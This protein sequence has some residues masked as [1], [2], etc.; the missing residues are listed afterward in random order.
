MKAP[1]PTPFGRRLREF[2]TRNNMDIARLSVL[3]GV[4]ASTL[5]RIESGR[6]RNPSE[7]VVNLLGSVFEAYIPLIPPTTPDI[8]A[9]NAEKLLELDDRLMRIEATHCELTAL[10][11][12]LIKQNNVI[13][14]TLGKV[15]NRIDNPPVI[16]M[17]VVR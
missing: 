12:A 10:V 13:L 15:L 5:R 1:V 9:G 7:R 17:S 8:V 11:S 4:S 3:S 2:R 14:K 6:H 16:Q